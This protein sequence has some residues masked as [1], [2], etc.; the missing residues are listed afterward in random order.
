M[1]TYY[2]NVSEIRKTTKV[3]I[4]GIYDNYDDA[5]LCLTALYNHYIRNKKTNVH[6][7]D[8]PRNYAFID[9]DSVAYYIYISDKL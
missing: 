5:M 4:K 6:Y 9:T 2:V 3:V 7:L 8:K 1:K